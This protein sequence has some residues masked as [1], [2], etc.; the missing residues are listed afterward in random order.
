MLQAQSSAVR[1]AR[2]I[3]CKL[4]LG[5]SN[6]CIDA[7]GNLL[8]L[9]SY[10]SYRTVILMDQ[11]ILSVYAQRAAHSEEN[12]IIYTWGINPFRCIQCPILLLYLLVNF[13]TFL[14]LFQTLLN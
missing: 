2:A 12:Y 8:N 1:I 3:I 13:E 6:F 7:I 9:Y 10:Y 5:P 14:S 11:N 4:E